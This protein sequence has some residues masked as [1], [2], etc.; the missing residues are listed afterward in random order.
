MALPAPA[1]HRRIAAPGLS[2][3]N[4][5]TLPLASATTSRGGPPGSAGGTTTPGPVTASRSS[6][7]PAGLHFPP[8]GQSHRLS[9]LPP[10]LVAND[11]PDSGVMPHAAFATLRSPC[12]GGPA[13]SA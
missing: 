9:F 2:A 12:H 13:T 4:S 6:H 1:L 8:A 11:P 5:H 10:S 3:A 7:D